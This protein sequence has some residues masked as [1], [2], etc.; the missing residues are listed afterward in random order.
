MAAGSIVIDLLM[1]TGAF[2]TDTKRA[3]AALRRFNKAATEQL[4]AA[5]IA[6]A[7]LAAAFLYMSKDAINAM[8]AMNDAAQKTG[9]TT[10]AL[11]QLGF[12]AKMSG[13]ETE[14]FTAAMV[15]FNKAIAEGATGSGAAATAFK[16][17][18]ISA[19][20]LKTA[21]PDEVLS[22]VAEK[23]AGFADGANKT[24]LAIAIFGR[25]GADMIPM[26][27]E[28]ADG[29]A[30]MRKEADAL[31]ATVSGAAAKS[32]AQFNDN[33]DKMIV[34]MKSFVKGI[35]SEVI[36]T[37]NILMETFL[38]GNSL[39]ATI[40]AGMNLN[41]EGGSIGIGQQLARAE[42]QLRE[43]DEKDK[44]RLKA[45]VDAYRSAYN[46]MRTMEGAGAAAVAGTGKPNAP[47]LP[48]TAA[49]KAGQNFLKGLQER[50]T[51]AGEGEIAM[52]RLQAAEKGVSA[53]AE[54][55]LEQLSS[56]KWAEGADK[57][58]ESLIAQT[59]SLAF[60][61]SLIGKSAK[62][63]ELLNIQ[64][65]IYADLQKQI[66]DLT[67]QNGTVSAEAIAEMTAA[68]EAQLAVQQQIISARQAEQE[69]IEF[70]INKALQSY[71]DNAGNAAKQAESLINGTLNSMT[72]G[73]SSAIE[74]MIFDSASLEE[75]INALAE[76]MLRSI[77]NALT[78]M[79]AQWVAYQLVQMAINKTTEAAAAT[80]ASLEAQ[81]MVAMAGLNAFAATA[82]IPIVGPA[83]APAAAAAAVAAT[84][85]MAATVAALSMAAAGAR[86]DGGPVTSG[87]PYLVGERGP[88]LFMPN[89]HGAIV[90]NGKLGG[91]SG[92]NITVNMIEDKRR[93]GQTQE[94]TNNDG[95]REI[96]VFVADILGD[97][98]RAKAVQKAFGLSRRGY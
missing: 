10:E 88:E 56:L 13:V 20:Q 19:E 42:L 60:Q 61:S 81:S 33:L 50:I 83:L 6:A 11:S 12:A 51:K 31:G 28:G 46:A 74:S 40:D 16:A 25:A 36:P 52:L 79:A 21:S 89:T 39:M 91:N 86:A 90:P 72:Q 66:Q 43:A 14:S 35:V 23:F 63:V 9:I 64:Y 26:L 7:A 76:N 73:F 69:T 65:R 4:Q 95:K 15:K 67:R 59:E 85:P 62:D 78:Q 34:K 8:D 98:P 48:D 77:V 68:A 37:M 54:P 49:D 17:I 18:G 84:E 47:A 55:L 27:N 75:T 58:S 32:A 22:M 30:E 57:F 82:A 97:G 80:A 44:A 71:V 2:E 70:G 93:A 29:I 96:D 41:L 87:K 1:R 38:A 5:G 3:E 53:A 92:G 94:K 45:K 24:A